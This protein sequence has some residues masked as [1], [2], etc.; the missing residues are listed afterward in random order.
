M[1]ALEGREL[2]VLKVKLSVCLHSNIQDVGIRKQL[3]AIII[4]AVYFRG[5]SAWSSTYWVVQPFLVRGD[6]MQ[7]TGFSGAHVTCMDW[8]VGLCSFLNHFSLKLGHTFAQLC[9]LYLSFFHSCLPCSLFSHLNKT[10]CFHCWL[11]FLY[12]TSCRLISKSR[13]STMA[14]GKGKRFWL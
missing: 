14:D 5:I 4:L 9:R 1:Y 10:E 2:Q 13:A 6:L 3:I 11:R 7:T 12:L 8:S